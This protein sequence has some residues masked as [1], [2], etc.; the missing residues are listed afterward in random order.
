MKYVGTFGLT[1]LDLTEA[2]FSDYRQVNVKC[3]TFSNPTRGR[4]FEDFTIDVAWDMKTGE[5][6]VGSAVFV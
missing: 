3:Y 1:I 4:L 6:Y 2:G 5:F